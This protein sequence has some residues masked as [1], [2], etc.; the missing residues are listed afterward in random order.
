MLVNDVIQS[1]NAQAAASGSQASG[2]SAKELGNNFM[3]MLVTQLKNQDPLNPMENSELTSQLAQINTVSGIED[4][5]ATLQGINSQIE[6]GQALQAAGV[7][8]KGVM[9]AGDRILVGPDG[10]S[11]P[12]GVELENPAEQLVATIVD[13]SG[14]PVRSFDLGAM[15]A[16]YQSFVWDGTLESGEYA[17]QGA[18]RVV[19]EAQ[20][21]D[22]S[23]LDSGTFNYAVVQAVSTD[24]QGATRL[25]LGG[26]SEQVRLQDV[27]QIL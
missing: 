2:N 19:V 21:G 16:G 10:A 12:F 20:A 11:T 9:V 5:N 18:Y 17:P 14:V 15:D 3:T 7:I 1:A 25:D 23:A 24:R 6:A 26:I 13:G 22:G 8:G 27:R 4:L